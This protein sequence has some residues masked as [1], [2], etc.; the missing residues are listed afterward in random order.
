MV[1]GKTV[2]GALAEEGFEMSTRLIKVLVRAL[3]ELEDL[4]LKL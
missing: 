2:V 1:H 4:A 3:Y